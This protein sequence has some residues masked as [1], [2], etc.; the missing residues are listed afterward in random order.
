MKRILLAFVALLFS[1]SAS[2]QFTPGQVLSAAQLNSALAAKTSNAAAA[3]TGGTI[4]GIPVGSMGYNLTHVAN[5]SALQSITTTILGI[6]STIH[7]DGYASAGDGGKMDYNWSSSACTLNSGAGDGGSQVQAAGIGCWLWDPQASGV[8]LEAFG[9]DGTATKDDAAF[10]SAIPALQNYSGRV[11][12]LLLGAKTYNVSQGI[13]INGPY[14]VSIRG[15]GMG[16]TTIQGSTGENYSLI[17]YGNTAVGATQ[18]QFG[19]IY[20]LR[21][22]AGSGATG[23]YAISSVHTA[24]FTVRDVAFLAYCGIEDRQSNNNTYD[25]IWGYTVGT[26][27]QAFWM[28]VT[29]A[30]QAAGG[31]TDQVTMNNVHLNAQYYGND[32]FVMTGMVQTVNQYNNTLMQCKRG[33][34]SDASQNTTSQFPQ[35]AFVYNLQVEGAQVAAVEIDGGRDFH[36]TDSAAFGDYGQT[37]S[38]GT[39]GNNDTAAFYVK[40][41][42][43]ASV[44]SNIDW[45]GGTIGNSAHQAALIQ[46]QGV[47]FSS[48]AFRNSSLASQYANPSVELQ[49]AGGF[50]SQDYQ[51][52]N[53][54]FCSIYG[55]TPSVSYGLVRDANVGTTIV[56]N[57][58]FASCHTGEISDASI[59]TN[60]A[61]YGGID[62]NQVP[63]PV[64]LGK[65]HSNANPTI[66]S[67]G[68][69]PAV[70][71]GWSNDVNGVVNT[72]TGTF[73]SCTVTFS[74]AWASAPTVFLQGT[75][76]VPFTIT[77]QTTT[78]FTF[79]RTD[80]GNLAAQTVYYR[81]TQGGN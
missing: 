60:L 1:V 17:S 49:G 70:G 51:F 9:G 23:G 28:H 24:N 40:P 19:G 72:G 39:Q 44:T 27:C 4:S 21:L 52:S 29:S 53:I 73:T 8:P 66:T 50:S 61:F 57:A 38:G 26:G 14:P 58:D 22:M 64:S 11:N 32:C 15:Q 76:T 25:N 7:R 10:A 74:S 80:G 62:R 63:L 69:S 71:T 79:S 31:R 36:F 77:G 2:A 37:G 78:S 16:V 45:K 46:A 54:K 35:F 81:S 65:F 42:G 18:T 12:T 43:S 34:F 6:F 5:N 33:W 67:C 55:E 13:T 30:D 47:R 56:S 59:G 20:G 41:D 68:T 75:G 3:I 48:M